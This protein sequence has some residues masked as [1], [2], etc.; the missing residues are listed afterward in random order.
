M[1]VT[2]EYA[3]KPITH[4]FYGVSVP[5]YGT[6]LALV[7]GVPISGVE[8]GVLGGPIEWN[9]GRGQA[10]LESETNEAPLDY[11]AADH[12][13]EMKFKIKEFRSDL[14]RFG[15]NGEVITASDGTKITTAGT[16]TELE[17]SCWVCVWE[18]QAG[19]GDYEYGIVYDGVV[20]DGMNIPLKKSDFGEIDM[21]VKARPVLTRP[22]KDQLGHLNTL[23]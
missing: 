12:S 4:V 15:T 23:Q 3:R 13:L 22:S 11:L 10:T 20:L 7:A 18:T 17:E 2:K 1:A 9:A 19:S 8:V 5:A 21:T 16:N 14:F 6:K